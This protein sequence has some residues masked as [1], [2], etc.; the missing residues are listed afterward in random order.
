MSQLEVAHRNVAAETKSV[1]SAYVPPLQR[2]KGQP[3]PVAAN[4]G[5]SYMS[6]DRE[7]DAGTGAALEDALAQIAEGESQRVIDMIHHAPPGPIETRWGLGFRKHDEC[8]EY[9]RANGVSAPEDGLALPLRYTAYERP[10]Y[11]VVPS[12]AVWRDPARADV[13]EI[14]RQNERDNLRRDLY[15]PQML[16]DARRIGEYYPGL[17]PEQPRMHGPARCLAGPP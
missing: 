7:G 13:A 3:P 5:L 15:F 17:S 6:F 16:R 11:S 12:N 8:M 1:S 2:T 9:I 4:G 14:L 10:T